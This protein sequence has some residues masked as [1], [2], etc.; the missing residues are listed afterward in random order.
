MPLFKCANRF[1]LLANAFVINVFS[2]KCTY[3]NAQNRFDLLANAYKINA[4]VINVFRNKCI[5]L[6]AQI[7]LI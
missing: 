7:D 1:D 5:C 2:N 3:L 6:N 4:F